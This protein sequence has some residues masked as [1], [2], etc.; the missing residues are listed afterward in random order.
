MREDGKTCD[1]VVGFV[2]RLVISF[3]NKFPDHQLR[4]IVRQGRVDP[5]AIRRLF[6]VASINRMSWDENW[7]VLGIT[8]HDKRP[9]S[10]CQI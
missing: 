5:F 3:N 9:A 2:I 4:Q 6:S 10:Q 7:F 1:L 8:G